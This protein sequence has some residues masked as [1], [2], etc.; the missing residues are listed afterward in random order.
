[1]FFFPEREGGKVEEKGE[2]ETSNDVDRKRRRKTKAKVAQD[3]SPLD[4]A[5]LVFVLEAKG[6]V[7]DRLVLVVRRGRGRERTRQG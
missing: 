6:L 3:D 2:K 4:L 7:L 1:M 5:R